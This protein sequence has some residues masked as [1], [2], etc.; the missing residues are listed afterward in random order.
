MIPLLVLLWFACAV[1]SVG[2]GLGYWKGIN[3]EYYRKLYHEDLLREVLFAMVC[4]PLFLF[5]NFVFDKN[6]GK[7]GL[8]YRKITN[9]DKLK[10][11]EQRLDRK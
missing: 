11:I 4:P 7:Y 2:V 8:A 9:K 5:I 3:P 10:L 1:L 6:F